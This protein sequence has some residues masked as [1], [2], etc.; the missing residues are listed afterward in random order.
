[1]SPCVA[2]VVVCVHIQF[3]V[4]AD[5]QAAFLPGPHSVCV[6]GGGVSEKQSDTLRCLFC[7]MHGISHVLWHLE[8][9]SFL[10][11]RCWTL[12]T[13]WWVFISQYL[14]ILWYFTPNSSQLSRAVEGDVTDIINNIFLTFCSPICSGARWYLL[15][16]SPQPYHCIT[17]SIEHLT[18]CIR[19]K[20]SWSFLLVIFL[21]LPDW[22]NHCH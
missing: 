5:S 21:K 4:P 7:R 9:K 10:S 18:S 2:P 19:T 11:A 22:P 20:T 15:I 1:M 17:V 8:N 16:M 6:C 12:L 13:C 14:L 3:D